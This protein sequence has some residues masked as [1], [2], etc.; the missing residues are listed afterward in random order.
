[1]TEVPAWLLDDVAAYDAMRDAGVS[2]AA[3]LSVLRRH[4]DASDTLLSGWTVDG[5]NR[6]AVESASTG[7]ST[8]VG[9]AGNN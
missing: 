7:F 2:R 6:G 5:T 4:G 9:G 3:D 8:P 1:M